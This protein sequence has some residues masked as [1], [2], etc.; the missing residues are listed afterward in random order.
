MKIET[1]QLSEPMENVYKPNLFDL[2]SLYTLV[3]SEKIV[4]CLEFGSGWSTLVLAA[5]LDENQKTYGE[6]FGIRHPNPFRLQ[7]IDCSEKFLELSMSRLEKYNLSNLVSPVLS[8]AKMGSF[9]GLACHFFDNHPPFTADLIYLDG[10][11]P[12][13]VE[14]HSNGFSVAFGDENR[15]YGLPMSADI[16]TMEYFFWPGSIIVVD[17]RGANAEFLRRNLTRNWDYVYSKFLD[18]HFFLL[19]EAPWGIYSEN[20]LKLRTGRTIDEIVLHCELEAQQFSK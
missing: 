1:L 6:D 5:A 18:Q 15:K 3:T 17:G 9:R 10:P 20:L 16:L 14:G 13:Q 8:K 19:R 4:S 7:T 12:D 2:A 11:D